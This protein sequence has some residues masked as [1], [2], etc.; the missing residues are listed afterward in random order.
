MVGRIVSAVV[1]V[2]V[3]AVVALVYW[4]VVPGVNDE[5]CVE[6]RNVAMFGSVLELIGGC[7]I[8]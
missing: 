3:V 7:W 4:F 2:V 8:G 1:A 5:W 6:A